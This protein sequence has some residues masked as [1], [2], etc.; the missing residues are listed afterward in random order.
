[1]IG[2]EKRKAI[3]L[4]H[5]EGMKQREIARRLKIG[6]NT[7]RT[8]IVAK[9]AVPLTVREDKIKIDVELLQKLYEECEGWKQRVHEKLVEEKGIKIK[10]STLTRLLRELGLGGEQ[11]SRCDQVPDKPG[12]EMQHDTTLYNV[13][14]AGRKV[15]VVASLLYFRYSKIR[16]LKFY[17]VFNRFA[18][19][20]FFHEALI[21]WGYAAVICVIDNTNLARLRGTGKDAVIVPEMVVFAEQYDF[22]FICHEKNHPNRKAGEERGL[23]TVETNFLPGRKFQSLEDLNQQAF[24][25]ATV[26]IY[27]RPVGKSGLIP[28]KAFEHEQA[29]LNKLPPHLPAPYRVLERQTDEYGY[30]SFDGNYYWVPGER[31]DQLTVLQFSE[32][33]KLYRGREQLAE[34]RLPATGVKNERFSPEGMP[35]PPHQPKNRKRPTVEEEK[36]L[37]AMAAVVNEYLDFALKPMGKERHHFLRQLF[38]LAQ[39]LTAALFTS[40]VERALKYRITA[41]ATIRRIALQL[42]NQGGETLPWVEVDENYVEREAYREG[43]LTDHPDP[44]QYDDLLEED[45]G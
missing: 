42:M 4:L 22:K 20:C 6:R 14:I 28:A 10:Y 41:I 5:Q 13:V 3:F 32:S 45:H 19:K 2:P 21:F 9:G 25:W 24:Q 37:R 12:V 26:R 15:R 27:H 31:R 36:R 1:M 35:T 38:Q 7:V 33:L 43:Q 16:Y 44:S 23:Y 39:Q 40:T 11:E 29:Y 17:L 8:I 30:V 34:Y 18:M